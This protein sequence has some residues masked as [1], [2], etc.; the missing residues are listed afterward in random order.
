MS[1]YNNDAMKAT[2][3]NT[4]HN[5]LDNNNNNDRDHGIAIRKQRET[6][7]AADADVPV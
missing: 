5:T 3:I 4:I 7:F 6:S 2:W 1:A